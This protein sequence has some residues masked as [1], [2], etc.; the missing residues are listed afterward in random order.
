MLS[1]R[2]LEIAHRPIKGDRVGVIAAAGSGKTAVIIERIRHLINNGVAPD[3]ICAFTF[4]LAAAAN[5]RLRLGDVPIVAGTFHSVSYGLM[6]IKP[7]ILTEQ[8]IEVMVRSLIPSKA[9]AAVIR[10][11]EGGKETPETKLIRSEMLALGAIDYMG[12]LINLRDK[13]KNGRALQS[14][15]HVIVDEAQDTDPVQWGIV[16]MLTDKGASLFAVGDPRQSIYEWRGANPNDFYQRCDW[17]EAMDLSYR[18][19]VDVAVAASG[20]ASQSDQQTS[21]TLSAKTINGLSISNHGPVTTVK[22]AIEDMYFPQDIAVLCRTNKDVGEIGLGLLAN[23]IDVFLP[24]NYR[25]SMCD[26][27]PLMKFLAYGDDLS[28]YSLKAS[29]IVKSIKDSCPFKDAVICGR[30]EEAKAIR[31]RWISSKFIKP[32][33][34]A[35]LNAIADQHKAMVDY[36]V[37]DY[38]DYELRDAVADFTMKQDVEPVPGKVWVS[39]IHQAKGLEWP[40]VIL[41][42]SGHGKPSRETWRTAY[43]GL[44]RCTERCIVVAYNTLF[45]REFIECIQKSTKSSLGYSGH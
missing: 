19:P 27:L 30:V 5:I 31:S 37:K 41:V 7:A 33:V 42:V 20:I 3:E 8:E 10:A 43:V 15:K 32:T 38:R 11:L 39:T 44:T 24:K 1:P 35:V 34:G 14:I 23:Q 25:D 13:L 45:G 22:G 9:V 36:W 40:C 12:L 29:S 18:L 26:L 4:T 16:D 21:D 17:R 6:V 2:Q 28:C